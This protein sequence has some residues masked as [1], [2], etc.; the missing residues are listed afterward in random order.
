MEVATRGKLWLVLRVLITIGLLVWLVWHYDWQATWQAMLQASTGVLLVLI[1]GLLANRLLAFY[2]LWLLLRTERAGIGL[3]TLLRLGFLASFVSNFL[4]TT[5]GG[6]VVKVAWLAKK[7]HAPWRAVLWALF[8]RVSNMAGVGLLLPFCLSLPFYQERMAGWLGWK[9]DNRAIFFIFCLL[10]LATTGLFGLWRVRH[11]DGDPIGEEAGETST[12]K[13]LAKPAWKAVG[14]KLLTRRGIF[15]LMVVVSLVS[16]LPNLA[17][18]WWLAHNLGIQVNLAEVTGV[19]VVIYFVSLIPVSIN[20]LGLQEVSTAYLY[21]NL[22]STPAQAAAL[23]VLLRLA[24]WLTS[25]PGVIWL[26]RGVL[27]VPSA[28]PGRQVDGN[29]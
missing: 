4:P 28:V 5:V 13:A 8:D 14:R 22:G 20:G 11:L 2:R 9:P 24:I 23:A 10:C 21:Q 6:D 17:A 29:V 16:I 19:Y 25:L 7:G 18:T 27:A 3:L 26:G 15:G 12:A 1:A